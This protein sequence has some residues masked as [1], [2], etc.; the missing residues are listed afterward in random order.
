MD[1]TGNLQI[2]TAL[3][4]FGRLPLIR[5]N[6]LEKPEFKFRADKFFQPKTRFFCRALPIICRLTTSVS[7][8][9]YKRCR[10]VVFKG[11]SS[12][13]T[14]AL[15]VLILG[16]SST[17]LRLKQ[18]TVTITV[19]STALVLIVVVVLVTFP[20]VSHTTFQD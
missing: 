9:S 20:T 2:A 8:P 18:I 7:F 5:E 13:V 6:R 12:S 15:I 3:S 19:V 16:T 14:A 4:K 11:I 10:F 1:L 17:A